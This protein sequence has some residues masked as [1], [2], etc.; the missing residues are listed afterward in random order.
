M[1]INLPKNYWDNK[2]WAYMHDP[3]DKCFDIKGH[4]ERAKKLVDVFGI[5]APN[6]DF[7]KT[8]DG[9]A[10][11]FERG[12]IVGYKTDQEKSGAIDF[13]KSPIL[14]H[15]TGEKAQISIKLENINSKDV[16][17]SLLEF[18][19]KEIG[20][21]AGE[22]GYSERFKNDPEKFAMARFFYTHLVLR[23]RLA[24][25][26]VGGI[27]ALWHRLPAD[28]RFPDH[29]IWQHNGL[30]SA[31]QSCFDIGEN[32]ND[33]G[34]MVFSITPVQGF[35]E[36]AR[37][38]RDY[39]VGSVF[40]S[41]LAF[42]GIRWVMENLGPDHILYPSLIDQFLVN[43][44]LKKQ[45]KIHEVKDF[46]NQER[47][48]ASFPNKF[49][50][51]IP[52]SKSEDIAKEVETNI[53]MAWKEIYEKVINELYSKL[54]LSNKE[55]E[56]VKYLFK[57]QNEN[58]WDIKWAA[59]RMLKKSDREK[60][61]EYLPEKIFKG[62]FI[63]LKYFEEMIKDKPYYE[64]S[65]IGV[66][67]SVS[68]ALCQAA[69]AAEKTKRTV[70]RNEE[71]GEK[72]HM[73]GEFEVLHSIKYNQDMSANDY[74]KM[75]NAFWTAL[76]SAYGGENSTDFKENEHL[77]SICLTKRIAPYCIKDDLGHLLQSTFM[78][79]E[80]GFPSTTY[81]ALN[82]YFK[83]KNI[84][85]HSEKIKEAQKIHEEEKDV[86]N[87]DRYYAILLMDGDNMG[88]LVGGETIAS[89]W[90]SIMHPEI[91]EKIEQGKIEKVYAENW[92]NIFAK[93]VKRNLT[94]SIHASISESLGDFAIY[95]VAKIVK[96]YEGK[97]I[98][99]GGDDVCAVLPMDK[100]LLAAEEISQYYKSTF[101]VIYQKDGEIVSEDICDN[102]APKP[103][104]LSVNLGKGENISISAGILICHHK[105]S[106][107]HMIKQANKLLKE[108]AKKEGGRNAV[109]IQ[110]KK[111]SGGDRFFVTKWN[112][113]KLQAFKKIS[114]KIGQSLSKRFAYKLAALENGIHSIINM[115]NLNEKEKIELLEKFIEKQLSKSGTKLKE[116]EI[117]TLSKDIREVILYKN[118]ESE[119]KFS[120]D[121][122]IIAG[123]LNRKQED[124]NV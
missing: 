27:G 69:L 12:Q 102:F 111:R 93:V 42:E 92:K 32:D 71:P 97:L 39:W 16:F 110:L 105:A 48:I 80:E 100:A 74:K 25:E 19:K 67:Y 21:K 2:F 68:H 75:I 61:E 37:K 5:T 108:K 109:A 44:Y 7:W 11:G 120:N 113:E 104:K 47:E 45:W 54:K 83:K 106:L 98:Y 28:T 116:D 3:F 29:T 58:F 55:I 119:V 4:V 40:L 95:G 85:S 15:P 52:F 35:I 96:K 60:V 8:A 107:K 78:R 13:L 99:A 87:Q 90:A 6:N 76:R 124:S 84:T 115:E 51:L 65:G 36:N 73:C 94:P 34:M 66:L 38:L 88:K 63:L 118:K 24:S 20:I 17:E 43:E 23:F 82:D 121:P 114:E 53:L 62:N 112:S 101:K 79:V 31:I 49:L 86:D 57:R 30:V 59:I 72:C 14:S 77:C 123:F 70:K 117:K 64:K 50:F 46:L 103:G 89:T 91:K 26:N 9:I 56:Y 18:L 33:L 81:M 41:Y 10:S 1:A 22:G 122:L